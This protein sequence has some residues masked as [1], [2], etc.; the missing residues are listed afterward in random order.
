[1]KH[2][3]PGLFLVLAAGCSSTSSSKP[4]NDAG[5][6]TGG[7]GNV[8]TGGTGNVATGGSGNVG[9]G[10]GPSGGTG[11]VS[12][13]GTGNTGNTG[14][15]GG[16]TGGTAPSLVPTCTGVTSTSGGSCY[17]S[18]P[19]NPMTNA[20]CTTAGAACDIAENGFQCYDPPNDVALCGACGEGA[21]C[22]PGSV[23]IDS[24]CL[25]YCC[26]DADCG[27]GK[28]YDLQLQNV[29]TPVKACLDA[30]PTG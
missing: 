12:T 23:C 3:V 15:T 6:N 9:T 7:T 17:P 22:Q 1:M 16:G 26:T 8:A 21:Y 25:H 4:G 27:S 11:G 5:Y 2:V 14:N 10:G 19:C 13:G 28:C 29:T 30:P 24:Q 20:G 18:T